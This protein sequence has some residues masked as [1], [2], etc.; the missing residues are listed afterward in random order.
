MSVT[1]WLSPSGSDRTYK[2]LKLEAWCHRHGDGKAAETRGRDGERMVTFYR[3][4]KAHGRH[5]RTTNVVESPLAALRLRT[6]AAQRFK[7]VERATA[8]IGKRR[9]VA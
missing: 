4:P 1:V 9:M 6:D 3:Y 5:L 2:G 7:K 8:V